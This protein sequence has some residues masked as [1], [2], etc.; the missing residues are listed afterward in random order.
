MAEVKISR[1]FL[2]L[3]FI[4]FTINAL[5]RAYDGR[6]AG[7]ILC[8]IAALGLLFSALFSRSPVRK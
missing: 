3:G 6:M 7:S 8:G 4:L 1:L 5:I 2:F